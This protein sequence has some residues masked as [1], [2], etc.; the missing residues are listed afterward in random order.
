M[1]LD[2]FR[3]CNVPQWRDRR[4]Y[5]VEWHTFFHWFDHWLQ[6]HWIARRRTSKAKDKRK[7]KTWPNELP[8]F[9]EATGKS[10]AEKYMEDFI[11]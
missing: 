10:L 1:L 4:D 3:E 5:L 2:E 8:R 6:R 7:T 9:T 11:F